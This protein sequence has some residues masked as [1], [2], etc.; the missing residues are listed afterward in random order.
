MDGIWLDRI[1]SEWI[2]SQISNLQVSGIV[3][4]YANLIE[5]KL[6]CRPGFKY[7]CRWRVYAESM[8]EEH[9]P[10][11]LSPEIEAPKNWDGTCLAVRLAAGFHKTWECALEID[12][13]IGVSVC[14]GLPRVYCLKDG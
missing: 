11:L 8:D 2:E 3:G 12:G 9:A 13:W 14:C 7:G 1:E 10:W 4:L 5:K 6:L